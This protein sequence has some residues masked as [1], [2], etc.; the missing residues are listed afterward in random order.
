MERVFSSASLPPGYTKTLRPRAAIER[1][2]V[3]GVKALVE[4]HDFDPENRAN[5]A[6]AEISLVA[7][8]ALEIALDQRELLAECAWRLS[9]LTPNTL[10]PK[11]RSEP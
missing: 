4:L 5:M 3:E 2:H 11:A 10:E 8:L 9:E 6:I 1:A 7:N